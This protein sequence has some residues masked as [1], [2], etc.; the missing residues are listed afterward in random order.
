MWVAVASG[1]WIITPS[2]LRWVG[3]SLLYAAVRLD[4]L[5]ASSLSTLQRMARAC[6]NAAPASAPSTPSH[7]VVDKSARHGG[8]AA[9]AKA[10]RMQ[11]LAAQLPDGWELEPIEDEPD[12]EALERLRALALDDQE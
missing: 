5:R 11:E 10:Q 2:A 3:F 12:V 8:L 1:A 7:V 6:V 4:R 9:S